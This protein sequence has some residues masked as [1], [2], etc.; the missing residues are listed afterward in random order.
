MSEGSEPGESGAEIRPAP[1]DYHTIT[2]WI[3]SRDT[4]QLLDFVREA[5]GAEE[6][7]RINNRTAPS[8]TPSS[9]SA[10]RW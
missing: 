3:I 7:A 5:F 8:G 4:A 2:P 9:G 1:E 6:I 10:T